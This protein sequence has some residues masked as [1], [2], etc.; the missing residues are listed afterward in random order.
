MKTKTFVNGIALSGL[1][2]SGIAAASGIETQQVDDLL[3]GDGRVV[4]SASEVWVSG[5]L[6]TD[7]STDLLHGGSPVN[8][9]SRS[10]F[11]QVADDREFSDDIIYGS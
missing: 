7:H 9:S 1:L 2:F 8:V 11:E 6:E 10:G 3:H 5:G 4:A